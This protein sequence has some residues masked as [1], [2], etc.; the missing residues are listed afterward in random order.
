[1]EANELRI[2]N[3]VNIGLKL[4]DLRTDYDRITPSGLMDL[5]VNKETSSFVYEP[6]PLT[7]EWLLK[8]GFN[9]YSKEMYFIAGMKIWKCNEIFICNKNGIVIK[10]VHQLQNLYFALIN[11]ELTYEQR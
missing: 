10:H 1:M 6:I 8:F 5:H 11:K 7:E 9:L 2:G 4:S 3:Y